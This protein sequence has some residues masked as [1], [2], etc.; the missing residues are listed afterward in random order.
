MYGFFRQINNFVGSYYA[1]ILLACGWET[2]TGVL[3]LYTP[4]LVE[5]GRRCKKIN[6][7]NFQWA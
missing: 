2:V 1:D 6:K 5:F 7:E 3:N 4:E